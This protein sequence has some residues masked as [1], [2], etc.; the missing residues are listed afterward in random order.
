M[1]RFIKCKEH[2][3]N[4]I[5][6]WVIWKQCT[7]G[8]SETWKFWNQT[9][10]TEKLVMSQFNMY[11][12]Q[13]AIGSKITQ[14]YLHMVCQRWRKTKQFEIWHSLQQYAF[15]SISGKTEISFNTTSKWVNCHL[16]LDEKKSFLSFHELLL[17][18]VQRFKIYRSYPN[19]YKV[20]FVSN[21]HQINQ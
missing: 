1:L 9:K 17:W 16:I 10:V 6:F 12:V 8:G 3:T 14:K 20:L 2:P 19:Q 4:G 11:A 7:L 5:S 15:K 18:R 13:M 21:N